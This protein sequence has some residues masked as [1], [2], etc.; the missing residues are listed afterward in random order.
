MK[1]SDA[2]KLA[3]I[4]IAANIPV[5]FSSA[6]GI[7]KSD[8]ARQLAAGRPLI[9]I[10]AS[11]FDRVDLSGVP[12]VL[13]GTTVWNPPALLPIESR[14]GPDGILFLDELTNA[15]LSVQGALL[16]LLLDRRLGEY[17]LPPSWRIIAA[18]NRQSDRA[19]ANRLSTAAGNRLG[20]IE[21]EADATDWTEW[22]AVNGI[23][24]LVIAFINFRPAMLHV[25]PTDGSA[26]FPSPRSWSYVSRALYEAGTLQLAFEIARALVGYGAAVEFAGFVDCFKELPRLPEIIAAPLST[27]V[28]HNITAKYA[29]AC[30]LGRMADVRNV[31]SVVTYLDRTGAEFSVLGVS[32]MIKRLPGLK[33]TSAYVQWAIR[34]QHVNL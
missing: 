18:G 10:R 23:H 6:P 31:D 30:M 12:S 32:Q 27:P 14:D 24:P 20:H 9:D 25:M 2:A 13:N 11:L 33:E 7:G 29:V 1:I 4:L 17:I 15:P 3:A 21:I 26:A 5:M 28:P 19:S 22:A 34:N 8:L 16:Q